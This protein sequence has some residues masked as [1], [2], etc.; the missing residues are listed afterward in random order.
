MILVEVCHLLPEGKAGFGL[1]TARETIESATNQVSESMAAEAI[2]G[3]QN[4]IGEE[5]Q[6]SDRD[7]KVAEI[8][9]MTGSEKCNERVPP[10]NRKNYRCQIEHI[11]VHVL[12]YE[13]EVRFARVLESFVSRD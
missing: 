12:E 3:K 2:A 1:L 11:P 4:D 13:G 9:E 5:N 6:C 10:E 8:K 7:L